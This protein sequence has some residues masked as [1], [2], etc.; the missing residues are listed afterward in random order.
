MKRKPT[1]SSRKQ[2]GAATIEY[3]LV[4][5]AVVALAGAV[6]DTEDGTSLSGKIMSKISSI[7]L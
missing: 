4:I 1:H 7:S 2:R 5:A 6:F 3:A